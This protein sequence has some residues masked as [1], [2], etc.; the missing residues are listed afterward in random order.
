M[1]I[2]TNPTYCKDKMRLSLPLT[3]NEKTS[4]DNFFQDNFSC[5]PI[6][7]FLL[8]THS[9]PMHFFSIPWILTFSLPRALGTNGLTLFKKRDIPA[10]FQFL[11]DVFFFLST[12]LVTWNVFKFIQ[13]KIER[14][15]WRG[16]RCQEKCFL[17][18]LNCYLSFKIIIKIIWCQLPLMT[19]SIVRHGS[20]H[21]KRKLKSNL[22]REGGRGRE[23]WKIEICK[24]KADIVHWYFEIFDR[25]RVNKSS[26]K[27]TTCLNKKIFNSFS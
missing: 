11:S 6:T 26:H 7:V 27:W 9:L 24:K 16:F 19:A 1:K 4:L 5:A 23:I 15:N 22:E 13:E 12:A 21:L 2:Q 17:N 18:Y 14:K 10:Q 8:L 20:L 3:N 25:K